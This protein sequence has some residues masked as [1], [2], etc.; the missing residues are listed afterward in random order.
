[1]QQLGFYCGIGTH[2]QS[3]SALWFG[4]PSGALDEFAPQGAQLLELPQGCALLGGISFLVITVHLHFP[5]EVMRQHGREEIDL[6]AGFSAGRHIIHL[7][8]RLEFGK[9]TFLGTASIVE[10][11]RLSGREPYLLVTIT[12]KS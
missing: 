5:V 12:L 8:L 1:M 2:G 4:Q 9:D 3:E 10:G 6:I 7:C 11:Q